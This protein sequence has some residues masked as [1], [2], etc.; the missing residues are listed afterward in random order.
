MIDGWRERERENE[1]EENE[2]TDLKRERGRQTDRG[3]DRESMR[4]ILGWG[5]KIGI[6]HGSSLH[7]LT[8]SYSNWPFQPTLAPKPTFALTAKLPRKLPRQATLAS[9]SGKLL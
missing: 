3:R 4:W 7:T 1:R 6:L 8:A 5:E 9:Y 2:T